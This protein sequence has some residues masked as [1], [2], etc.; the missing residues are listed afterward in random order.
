MISAAQLFV[1]KSLL[2]VS[3]SAFSHV[4]QPAPRIE[5][6]VKFEKKEKRKKTKKEEDR[7]ELN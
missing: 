7:S 2:T 5:S 3:A 1:C 6:G 4:F